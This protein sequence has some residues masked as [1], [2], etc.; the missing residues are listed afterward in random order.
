MD[1]T[2]EKVTCV[3][4][5]TITA[6]ALSVLWSAWRETCCRAAAKRASARAAAAHLALQL[7][8]AAFDTWLL[9]WMQA[10]AEC[11]GLQIAVGQHRRWLLRQVICLPQIS[12]TCS[13]LPMGLQ[14]RCLGC[15]VAKIGLLHR[16]PIKLCSD[17][18]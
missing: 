4:P 8:H 17:A 1:Y 5:Q 12:N 13:E 15:A 9:N 16:Y 11:S 6:Q 10:A 3:C 2:K 18:Y 7:A 14:V